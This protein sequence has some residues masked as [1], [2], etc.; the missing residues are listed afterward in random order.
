MK[1]TIN[2]YS[3]EFEIES[4]NDF[5]ILFALVTSKLSLE[6][7]NQ[8]DLE[9]YYFDKQKNKKIISDC[10]TLNQ[11]FKYFLATRN[12]RGF[13]FTPKI[14]VQL[15]NKEDSNSLLQS[16]LSFKSLKA[17]PSQNAEQNN[18]NDV[19][20]PSIHAA[21]PNACENPYAEADSSCNEKNQE[22]KSKDFFNDLEQLNE[23][24]SNNVNS[25][26]IQNNGIYANNPAISESIDLQNIKDKENKL[27]A[28]ND[29]K[30]K[31][32]AD[33]NNA[34]NNSKNVIIS[35]NKESNFLKNP[36]QVNNQE[37]N[38]DDY[39][40]SNTNYNTGKN[41]NFEVENNELS[42]NIN[43]PI[44]S[45]E[46]ENY[47]NISNSKVESESEFVLLEKCSNYSK[48]EEISNNENNNTQL[49]LQP[50]SIC[51]HNT[52]NSLNFP[53]VRASLGSEAALKDK[54]V[55]NK[56][57]INNNEK[58]AGAGAG[59][60]AA[61][62][63]SA[64][65]AAYKDLK[66]KEN[67]AIQKTFANQTKSEK[68]NEEFISNLSE[69]EREKRKSLIEH[70]LKQQLINQEK[71]GNSNYLENVLDK[72]KNYLP[73]QIVLEYSQNRIA[74][75]Q[76][77]SEKSLENTDKTNKN[78]LNSKIYNNNVKKNIEKENLIF[79]SED[80][81]KNQIQEKIRLDT[82]EEA[83]SNDASEALI[84]QLIEEVSNLID[85]QFS[86]C[87]KNILEKAK[88]TIVLRLK[89]I[90][91]YHNQKQ[92]E[93]E[94]EKNKLSIVHEGVTCDGCLLSP[95]IGDRYKCT[96]CENFDYC[97][98]CE[99]KYSEMHKHPFLKIKNLEQT[100]YLVKCV[101]DNNTI[102]NNDIS[103]KSI[104]NYS[105]DHPKAVEN[106][107]DNIDIQSQAQPSQAVDSN[108]NPLEALAEAAAQSQQYVK[109]EEKEFNEEAEQAEDAAIK[110]GSFYSKLIN[111]P[112]KDFFEEVKNI[113]IKKIPQTFSKLFNKDK[114][115]ESES[116]TKQKI[117]ADKIKEIRSNYVL[118][119][120]SDEQLIELLEKANDDE[121]K[122]FQLLIDYLKF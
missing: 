60:A 49:N 58:E 12:Q 40:V 73:K 107:H 118:P 26:S 63:S 57:S 11:A 83:Y 24:L 8:K 34:D 82:Y 111:S 93:K 3:E 115:S 100:K 37:H 106:I 46:V 76:Q 52:N 25:N 74:A 14:F 5:N 88:A 42:V 108:I 45:G 70:T 69:Q 96:V 104:N 56:V 120:I 101:L 28:N 62:A 102:D 81:I 35:F 39:Y 94:N 59:A 75:H 64:A 15:A 97:N 54:L 55:T 17:I 68:E 32:Y 98:I 78:N 119:D 51:S 114:N 112:K 53:L 122:L 91:N 43:H 13:K 48:N 33:T 36:E 110:G 103:S 92:K 47:R 22:K 44:N 16:N 65:D 84:Q 23:F 30:E 4:L 21:K 80:N 27:N 72:V 1:F 7:C 20:L 121:D 2:F 67:L 41:G 29:Y 9:F 10:F 71:I 18:K 38:L 61:A 116:T 77:E 86:K 6:D 113:F 117:Y 105:I 89:S 109:E 66:E 95:I 50:K 87:K 99:D 85:R 79:L 19:K 90:E 31:S